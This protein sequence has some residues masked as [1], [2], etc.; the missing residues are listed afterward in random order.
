VSDN[1]N[2]N[3]QIRSNP[4]SGNTSSSLRDH[5]MDSAA[6]NTHYSSGGVTQ[7]L[8]AQ[9]AGDAHGVQSKAY[10]DSEELETLHKAKKLG[11]KY[12]DLRQII[13]EEDYI[14]IIAKEDAIKYLSLPIAIKQGKLFFGIVDPYKE[15]LTAF[16]KNLREDHDVV[17][18]LI[19]PESFRENIDRYDFI[20]TYEKDHVDQG[21]IDIDVNKVTNIEKLKDLLINDG[22]QF[23]LADLLT[24]AITTKSSDVHI[25][26]QNTYAD[27]RFRIDGA[28]HPIA[29]VPRDKYNYLISEII[30][31]SALRLDA[32]RPQNGHLKA[33]PNLNGIKEIDIRVE[34][35]PVLHGQEVVMRLF[36]GDATMLKLSDLGITHEVYPIIKEILVRP[37]GMMIVVGPTGSGKTSTLY[38]LLNE[39]NNPERKIVT[40]EDPVEYELPGL[41]Q[42]QLNT[43]ESFLDRFRAVLREDPDVIM[44]GEIRDLDTAKTALQSA[45]TGHLL[46]T[47]YHANNAATA[48]ARLTDLVGDM[49]L[50]SS[51][52]NLIVAQ[53]LVRKICPFCRTD[54]NLNADEAAAVS[55]ILAH[56]PVSY[57]ER[58]KNLHFYKGKGCDRCYGIGYKSRIGIFEMLKI[59]T[60]M[61]QL[62]M[63]KALPSVIQAAAVKNGMLTMEQDGILKALQGFTT[64]EEILKTVKE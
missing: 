15:G 25:E 44:I 14:K 12:A 11:I 3:H 7:D 39:L 47:T 35:I 19:S 29:R 40:L 32:D 31:N 10:R 21:T 53:R 57:Q 56:L 50:I 6:Q 42:S 58:A 30:I 26:P 62:I 64:V 38:A 49:S 34:T 46:L 9:Y 24:A 61:Q 23:L 41:S 60:D 43:G 2:V 22:I 33:I 55:Q 36:Q 48:I 37:H 16:V 18:V 20:K 27:I 51:A 52:I 4:S 63:S 45:L 54:H 8:H 13:P 59:T 5:Y 1:S 28:L 17:V